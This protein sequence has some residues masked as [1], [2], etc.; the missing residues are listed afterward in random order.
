MRTYVRLPDGTEAQLSVEQDFEEPSY[1][2]TPTKVDPDWTWTDR[3]GHVHDASLGKATWT[4]VRVYWCDSCA[5]EHE[6]SDLVCRYCGDH[7]VPRRVPDHD[8]LKPIPG[9]I[10]ATLKVR[11]GQIQS[12]YHVPLAVVN[13]FTGEFTPEWLASAENDDLLLD[14]NFVNW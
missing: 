13:E 12:S 2:V 5:E 6:E 14:R 8:A 3:A 7:V 4:V 9:L 1:L 10:N 11:R